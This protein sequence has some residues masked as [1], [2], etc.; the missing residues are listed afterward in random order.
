M[1]FTENRQEVRKFLFKVCSCQPYYPFLH[2]VQYQVGETG[3]IQVKYSN[4]FSFNLFFV[5]TRSPFLYF[6]REVKFKIE[7]K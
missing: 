5:S 7:I 3:P 1:N 4:V 2:I 6:A